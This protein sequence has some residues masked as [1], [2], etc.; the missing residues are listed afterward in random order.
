MLFLQTWLLGYELTDT[1]MVLTED[2]IHFLASKKKVDF[3]RQIEN[4][5]DDSGLPP[6]KLHVRDRV[7]ISVLFF[8]M[9]AC[10]VKYLKL[11]VYSL[12]LVHS[13]SRSH[14]WVCV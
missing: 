3:L 14:V 7:C 10:V 2:A 13:C 11:A 12:H 6:V 5:K 4:S 9:N 8:Y 1:I